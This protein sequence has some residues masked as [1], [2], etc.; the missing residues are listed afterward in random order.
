MEL[1]F[2]ILRAVKE[3][4][5]NGR[6]F[7]LCASFFLSTFFVKGQITVNNGVA[8][9]PQGQV[10]II[11]DTVKAEAQQA[12]PAISA[13]GKI[14]IVEGTVVSNL[15]HFEVEIVPVERAL[16]PEIKSVQMIAKK[17]SSAIP[18]TRANSAYSYV[19]PPNKVFYNAQ[20]SSAFTQQQKRL[21]S[22]VI[23]STAASAKKSYAGLISKFNQI[24]WKSEKGHLQKYCFENSAYKIVNLRSQ[25]ARPPPKALV[26]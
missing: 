6:F 25:L 7:L 10:L 4:P 16:P 8:F 3:F 1:I 26:L 19:S 14:F 17:E 18:K 20:S 13:K 24:S 23:S 9:S 12:P 5:S 21:A 22:A 11:T 15:D 2:R